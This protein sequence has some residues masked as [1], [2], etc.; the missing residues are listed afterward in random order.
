MKEEKNSKERIQEA[1]MPESILEG[2]FWPERIKVISSKQIGTGFEVQGIGLKSER[3]YSRIL[4]PDDLAKIKRVELKQ[5]DFSGDAD[6]FFLSM[7]GKRIRFAFQFDPL[8]AVN[9]SQIDPLPHQIDAVYHYILRH[10]KIR[11]LLA[12]DPGA[13]KT[14]MAGL[15]LKELKQRGLVEK[16]LIVIPGHL[17]D[18]WVR[19][20]KEKF[21]ETFRFIDRAIMDA[22]WGRNIWNEENQ[23]I[24][25]MDFAKQEDVMISLA[26]AKWDLV[27]VDEA[28][29]MAAYE[30]GGQMKRTERYKLG[31]LLS[32]NSNFLLLLTATPHRGDP[33]NFRLFLD[34]LEP[35][36][37]ATNE[38][39]AESIKHK[40]NPLF[41]RRLKEDLKNFD[42]TPLFPPRKVI[43]C[44]Y[45]LSDDE[46]RLYNAVTEYVE[47][48]H[49]RAMQKEKRNVAFAL[50]ILQRRLASSLRAIRRS[51]ER[52][53]DRLK[54]LHEQGKLISE[55]GYIDEEAL[56]DSTELERWRKED[57][58][59]EKLTSAET[60]DELLVE[61]EKLDELIKLAKEA[62]KKEV[63]TKLTEL[64]KVMEQEGSL[65]KGFPLCGPFHLPYG[66]LFFLFSVELD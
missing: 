19:E 51:L 32:R 43:T 9:V 33:N 12:D 53:R 42:G 27:I 25:S 45:R 36:F 38:M 35:G 22:S 48:Y 20:L 60:L 23:A 8:Y 28:H 10:P 55:V 18:Q 1:P 61:I 58:L 16:V 65:K 66:L 44:K 29:K 21:G 56:E 13:G 34:L 64:K 4:R 40:D 49:N 31:E 54:E 52:R 50:L 41:L 11:F 6:A 63:E 15:I 14:I 5:K 47:K 26:E 57:E 46:K 39:L 37:F 17:R 7:E 62:E 59:L 2:P 24:T 3:F 30:Y